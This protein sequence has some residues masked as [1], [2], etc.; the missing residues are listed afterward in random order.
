MNRKELAASFLMVGL[1]FTLVLSGWILP[2][3]TLAGQGAD[4]Y[5]RGADAQWSQSIIQV[6]ASHDDP[7]PHG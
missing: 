5:F 1:V 3:S 4:E 6:P 7:P 2:N